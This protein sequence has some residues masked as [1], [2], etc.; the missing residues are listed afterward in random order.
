MVMLCTAE[1]DIANSVAVSDIDAFLTNVA[2]AIQSTYQIVLKDT[3]SAAI[4]GQDM[5]FDIP[6]PAD[7]NKIGDHR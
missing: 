1:L 5:L 4:F 2:W 3:P 6:F 7:W